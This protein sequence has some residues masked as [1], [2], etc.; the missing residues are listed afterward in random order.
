MEDR[1]VPQW[2][3]ALA[4]IDKD[5]AEWARESR[6]LQEEFERKTAALDKRKE[7]ILKAQGPVLRAKTE[8]LHNLEKEMISAG[9]SLEERMSSVETDGSADQ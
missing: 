1:E 5:Y 9:K 6:E 8:W 7:E 2:A 4:A 3:V